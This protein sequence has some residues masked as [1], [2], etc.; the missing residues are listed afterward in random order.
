MPM[1]KAYF[2]I[3]IFKRVLGSSKILK[4]NSIK[5]FWLYSIYTMLLCLTLYFYTQINIYLIHANT[6]TRA[7]THTH[8]PEMD[9]GFLDGSRISGGGA[10]NL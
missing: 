4:I 3:L 5:N 6:H 8:T 9:P 1:Y 10:V 2:G 7:H